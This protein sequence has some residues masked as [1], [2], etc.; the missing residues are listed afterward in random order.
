MARIGLRRARQHGGAD[1]AETL[2]KGATRVHAVFDIVPGGA[3][4]R[5]RRGLSPAARPAEAARGAEVVITMLPAGKHVRD[6]WLGEAAWPPPA[7]P[8]PS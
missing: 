4:G 6:A 2:A 3:G 1:G 5:R 7:T 8:A